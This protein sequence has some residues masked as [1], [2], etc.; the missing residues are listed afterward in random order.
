MKRFHYNLQTVLNYEE[1]VLDEKKEEYA[2]RLEK[3]AQK[4][5][6]ID[7]LQESSD[8]LNASFDEV[9][10]QGAKIETF[11][12]YSDMIRNNDDQIK[13]ENARLRRLEKWADEKK[14]EVIDANIDVKK[15]DKL[16]EKKYAA[17]RKQEAK[18]NEAFIEE[19]VQHQTSESLRR[20]T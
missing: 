15:Y 3:V 7:A 14:Q 6:Q 20:N 5:K 16:K 10:K 11:L 18:E 19:F 2:G 13:V 8:A 12:L 1:Q 4:K 17:Y 9:K